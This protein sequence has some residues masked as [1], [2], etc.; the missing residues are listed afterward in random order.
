MGQRAF[1]NRVT[2]SLIKNYLQNNSENSLIADY[3]TSVGTS[4][5]SDKEDC[6]FQG[7]LI[8]LNMEFNID[9]PLQNIKDLNTALSLGLLNSAMPK[10]TKIKNLNLI[11]SSSLFGE[12]KTQ[13]HSNLYVLFG[14]YFLRDISNIS[15]KLYN[16]TSKKYYNDRKTIKNILDFIC[17]KTIKSVHMNSSFIFY[18]IP[19]YSEFAIV[20]AYKDININ[21]KLDSIEL[22]QDLFFHPYCTF[23]RKVENFLRCLAAVEKTVP[24]EVN[25]IILPVIFFK[26]LNPDI[27]YSGRKN[28]FGDLSQFIKEIRNR[29]RIMSIEFRVTFS[30]EEKSENIIENYILF[31]K[32]IIE[33]NIHLLKEFTYV[34]MSFDFPEINQFLKL[35]QNNLYHNSSYQPVKLFMSEMKQILKI[36][37]LANISLAYH[38]SYQ[39]L[40]TST[41]L[42]DKYDFYDYIFYDHNY[43][44]K[45]WNLIFGLKNN[46]TTYI[47]NR[48]KNILDNLLRSVFSYEKILNQG[49]LDF[50][51]EFVKNKKIVP[52]EVG[53]NN[54]MIFSN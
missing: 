11:I 40:N 36:K 9:T 27:F 20:L 30:V 6:F 53:A 51:I 15:I 26:D 46:N 17:F 12:G 31:I 54:V 42:E 41:N 50:C 16:P 32:K 38:T 47:L 3:S 45:I 28:I 52:L 35:S 22:M 18:V 24:S 10:G 29:F 48:R 23:E 33:E 4:G 43:A 21:E 7:K 14:S 13:L 37:K 19:E 5:K 44:E 2:D 8:D 49:Q 39:N 25:N 1:R 34:Y